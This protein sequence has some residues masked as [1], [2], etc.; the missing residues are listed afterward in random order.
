MSLHEPPRTVRGLLRL[1]AGLALLVALLVAGASPASAHAELSSTDPAVGSVVAASPDQVVLRFTEGISVED[2]GVRVLD[3]EAARRDAGRS[4]AADGVVTVPLDGE[5]PNGGYVVA[6]R[7][8]SADGHPIQGAFQFSVGTRTQIDADIAGAAFGASADTRDKTA[9]TVLRVVAYLGALL[10]AG[11]TFVGSRLHRRG[12]PSPVTRF[13]ALSAGVA[14]LALLLQIPV[15]TSLITGRG[16][17]SVTEAGVLGRALGEGFGL[18][19]G[20]TT[21]GLVLIAITSGLPFQGLVRLTAQL[22][23]VL[24]PLGFAFT[25]HTRTMS[26]RVVA[27]GADV[28]H[29]LAAALWFGGLVALVV[30][31]ARRR[32]LDDPVSAGSAVGEFSAL[33]GLALAV[34]AVSGGTMGWIEVGGLQALTTTYYGRLLMAKVALVGFVALA[35]AWNRFGLVPL[36][37]GAGAADEDEDEEHA[38]L[39]EATDRQWTKLSRILRAEVALLV[40]A[41]AITGVLVNATPAKQQVQ[42][43]V[44]VTRADFGDG[45][46]EIWVDPGRPGRN[47][48]HAVILGADGAPDDS[49]PTAQFELRLPAQDIG[50]IA[51]EPV[52]VGAGHFQSVGVDLSIGGRWTLTVTVRPDRF[53]ETSGMAE[54]EIG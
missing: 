7:V 17:G 50:P 3:V 13:V 6:W 49:Y 23:S 8:V 25:G 31:V 45:S 19:I 16:W 1:L 28:A 27:Y 47:D 37:A 22:G 44:V 48:L 9:A 43:S 54:F 11:Y 10:A 20:I 38:T 35:G 21:L 2:D 30:V 33:A 24:A 51:S 32:R 36:L 26:P 42:A 14:A 52:R 15:Q 53:T 46:I 4:S 34:V 41:V 29:L 39:R 12:E 18:A 5:L 40:L